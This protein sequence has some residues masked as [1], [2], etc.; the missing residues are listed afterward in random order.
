VTWPQAVQLGLDQEP[1]GGFEVVD[2]MA[3][4]PFQPADAV[5]LHADPAAVLSAT[6]PAAPDCSTTVAWSL[7]SCSGA[8]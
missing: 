7:R 8:G 5:G 1:A 4:V 6:G 2:V 3:E